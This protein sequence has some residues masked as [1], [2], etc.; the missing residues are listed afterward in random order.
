MIRDVTRTATV[1]AKGPTTLPALEREQFI[2]AVTGHR[3]SHE[4]AGA[5]AQERLG[6]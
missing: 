1:R 2:A 4:A 3:R 6:R 5:V